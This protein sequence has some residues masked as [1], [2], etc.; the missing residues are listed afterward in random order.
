M[1]RWLA[2]CFL[3]AV[4]CLALA[5]PGG[6]GRHAELSMLVSGSL[7]IAPDGSVRSHTV[8][9]SKK[10]PASLNAYIDKA[11]SAWKFMPVVVDGKPVTAQTKMDLRLIADRDEHGNYVV[12]V[13]G[14]LFDGGQPDESLR[15]AADTNRSPGYPPDAA[16]ARA[17]ATVYLV[18]KIG[19]QGQVLDAM[20]EQVNLT[21]NGSVGLMNHLRAEFARVSLAAAR[22]WK[23]IPPTAGPQADDPYWTVRT[24]VDFVIGSQPAPAA[25]QY[26]HWQVYVPGPRQRVPWLDPRQLAGDSADAAPGG[27]VTLLGHGPRLATPLSGG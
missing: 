18:L 13:G 4:S 26:A 25:D 23:F 16:R 5:A 10:L 6:A 15:A 3:A 21:V 2:G 14:A 11:I 19:R 7:V 24:P 9:Q 17:E 22:R 8:D 12:R 1:K 20:A 27:S